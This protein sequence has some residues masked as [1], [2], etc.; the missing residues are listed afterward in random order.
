MANVCAAIRALITVFEPHCA[1]C[2][3]LREL[4][5]LIDDGSKR[6]TGHDL[7]HRI[8]LKTLSAAR[9]GDRL[10]EAQYEFEEVC[11]KTLYN[12]S[13]RGRSAPFDADVPFRIVPSAFAFARVLEISDSE[14]VQAIVA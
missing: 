6:W 3:T 9:R 12:L 4:T 10:L 13:G 8:R 1:D 5:E 14:I 7:F 2:S 11:A